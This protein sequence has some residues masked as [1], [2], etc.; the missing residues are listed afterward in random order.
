MDAHGRL[1]PSSTVQPYQERAE[2]DGLGGFENDSSTDSLPCRVGLGQGA[3]R[4]L[5]FDDRIPRHGAVIE[6][7]LAGQSDEENERGVR[8]KTY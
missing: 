3:T 7:K 6:T 8:V 1:G 2:R 5:D 4:K